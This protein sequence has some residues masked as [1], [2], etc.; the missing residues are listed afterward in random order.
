MKIDTSP[1][2]GILALKKPLPIDVEVSIRTEASLRVWVSFMVLPSAEIVEKMM[3]G[4]MSPS[5]FEMSKPGLWS[6]MA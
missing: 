1:V 4:S 2:G 6:F 5:M 3:S